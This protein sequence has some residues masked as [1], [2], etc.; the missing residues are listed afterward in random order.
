M[1][2]R[3]HSRA[4]LGW[5]LAIE[6][7]AQTGVALTAGRADRRRFGEILELAREVSGTEA[8]PRVPRRDARPAARLDDAAVAT[9]YVTPK[10]RASVVAVLDG[11]PAR[12]VLADRGPRRPLG[13][14]GDFVDLDEY[15][16]ETAVRVGRVHGVEVDRCGL[17]VVGVLDRLRSATGSYGPSYDVVFAAPGTPASK[18][19][20]RPAGT[21]VRSVAATGP[22]LGG[23][24]AGR[25][26]D[27]ADGRAD[28]A[29][30]AD[31]DCPPGPAG[32]AV[33][34]VDS[35][36]A[37]VV[38]AA[39]AAVRGEVVSPVLDEPRPDRVPG[40]RAAS[41]PPPRDE[42]IDR[43]AVLAAEGHRARAS[44]H[45]HARYHEISTAVRALRRGI[46]FVPDGGGP[47]WMDDRLATARAVTPTVCVSVAV[48]DAFGRLLLMR[49]AMSGQWDL[50]SGYADPGDPPV[51]V[52]VKEA[53][54]ELGLAVEV[55]GLLGVVDGMRASG[56][57]DGPI[58]TVV[59]TAYVV[60]GLLRIDPLEATDVAWFRRDRLP[61]P[62]SGCARAIAGLAFDRSGAAPGPAFFDAPR[63]H[64]AERSLRRPAWRI[65]GSSSGTSTAR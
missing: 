27:G 50:V 58:T 49:R 34:A 7:T 9:R 36:V 59:L 16:A 63:S 5:L 3:L 62:L 13:L 47:V 21:R 64:R 28:G 48:L 45:D 18:P 41:E 8:S 53:A 44:V 15:P 35:D 10:L 11:E 20:G 40:A 54:E 24:G 46:P 61:W 30:G 52:A 51:G 4:L 23:G 14:A 12:V 22:A 55:T 43:V 32:P 2:A 38:P 33:A 31:G 65:N 17:R 42:R 57:T 37:R 1:R 26:H 6:A 39:L 60:S 29:D 19:P 56:G 25:A